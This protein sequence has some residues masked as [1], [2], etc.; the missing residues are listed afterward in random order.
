MLWY[1]GFSL[2]SRIN[3][4]V[5]AVL[6]LSAKKLTHFPTQPN[7]L[8]LKTRHKCHKMSFLP[9]APHTGEGWILGKIPS[10]EGFSSMEQGSEGSTS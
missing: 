8:L 9:G 1:Q 2:A 5:V 10:L 3:G 7:V 4:E 6:N